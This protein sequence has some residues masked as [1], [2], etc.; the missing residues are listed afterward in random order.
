[1]LYQFIALNHSD[2][3]YSH[4]HV[5]SIYPNE[6]GIWECVNESFGKVEAGTIAHNQTTFGFSYHEN[7]QAGT[8]QAQNV[9]PLLKRNE[10]ALKEQG[11]DMFSVLKRFKV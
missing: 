2:I 10:Q 6:K 3:N 11:Q 7:N 9:M 5:H 4:I 1:M 8:I